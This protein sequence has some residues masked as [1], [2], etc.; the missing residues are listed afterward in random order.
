MPT[1]TPISVKAGNLLA[2]VRAQN[3]LVH[4][5]TNFVAMNSSANILLAAGASPVM[6]HAPQEVGEMTRLADALVLNIGTLEDAW[7][8][9]MLLAGVTANGRRIPVVLDPVGAGA[10]RYRTEA[11]QRIRQRVRTTVIRA[12]YSEILAL[13]SAGGGAR[14]VDS[15]QRL[16]ESAAEQ[17]RRLAAE[18]ACIVAVSGEIDLISDGARVFLVR[19]GHALMPRVTALGCGLSAVVGAWCAG[20]APEDRPALLE[21][22]AAA[23]G[24]Y[25]LAGEKAAR[26]AAGPGSFFPAF[27]DALYTLTP[28]ETAAGLRIDVLPAP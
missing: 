10:T 21:A 27:L 24:F 26:S 19:N 28:E 16:E 15:N 14:G 25:G 23:F 4:N 2:A 7:I 18:F 11:A 13:A 3:P 8:E 9:S 12:N 6:A 22:T 1:P 17:V 20:I 5:I